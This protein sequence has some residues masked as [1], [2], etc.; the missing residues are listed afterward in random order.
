MNASHPV[1]EV[2]AARS[3][4]KTV[5]TVADKNLFSIDTSPCRTKNLIL[6]SANLKTNKPLKQSGISGR[7][8]PHTGTGG[9]RVKVRFHLA[10]DR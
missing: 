6:V 5:P 3:P 4:P 7:F 2:F 10:I 8:F 1:I 9:D